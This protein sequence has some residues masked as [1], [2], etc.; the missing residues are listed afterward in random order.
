MKTTKAILVL[1]AALCLLFY[2]A[3]S[4]A[5]TIW[6]GNFTSDH[7]SNPANHDQPPGYGGPG[8]FG[9]VELEAITGGFQVTVTLKDGSEFINTGAGAFQNFGFG[10]TFIGT[11]APAITITGNTALS[12][13]GSHSLTASYAPNATTPFHMDGGG[14]FFYG[15]HYTGQGTGGAN[16]IVGPIVFDVTGNG[17][18]LAWLTAANAD[19]QIFVA[20]VISGLILPPNTIAN[21]GLIDVNS[22]TVPEPGILILLGIAMSAIGM[23]SWRISK[24]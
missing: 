21:T 8:P 19:N 22:V 24:I 14:D 16:A 6:T 18:T 15:V 12:D 4:K 5:D 20:D 23:A 11:G 17:V 9:T 3:T 2:P 1:A 13:S 10:A 7:I